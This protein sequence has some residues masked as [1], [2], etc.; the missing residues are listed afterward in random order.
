MVWE[1]DAGFGQECYD[2]EE[3]TSE[4]TIMQFRK[5]NMF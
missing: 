2:A 3:D 4:E 5:S 1:A